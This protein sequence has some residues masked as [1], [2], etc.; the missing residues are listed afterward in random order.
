MLILPDRIS[1]LNALSTSG[2]FITVEGSE[3][4]GK[5]T[6]LDYLEKAVDVGAV[7]LAWMQNDEDLVSVRG[8]PRYAAMLERIAPAGRSTE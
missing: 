1:L 6:A 4:A 5:T 8:H 2:L 3:G 7:S